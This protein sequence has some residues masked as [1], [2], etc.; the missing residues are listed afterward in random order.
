MDL[1]WYITPELF[2]MSVVLGVFLGLLPPF[3]KWLDKRERTGPHPVASVTV[4]VLESTLI[5]AV[6]VLLLDIIP[7]LFV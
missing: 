7:L 3:G 1:T 5:I 4:I 2:G 6:V